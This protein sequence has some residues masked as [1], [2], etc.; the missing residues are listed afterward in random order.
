MMK[1]YDET[2][3][4]WLQLTEQKSG[5]QRKEYGYCPFSSLWPDSG[6]HNMVLRSEMAYELGG[7]ALPALGGTAVTE[8]AELV[9]ADMIELIGPDLQEIRSDTPYARLALIRVKADT[10]GEGEN[11]YQAIRKMEYV[12]YHMNPEGFMIR[13][14]ALH[15]QECVRVSKKALQ[16]GLTFEKTG[17]LFLEAW[18]RIPN[19]AAVRLIFITDPQFPYSELK[20]SVHR[21]D[22][23]TDGIDHIMKNLVMD[24]S[25]CRQKPLCD[26]VEGMRELHFA[27]AAR[28]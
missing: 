13:I 3:R 14:S 22:L 19:T 5:N 24:C 18:H 7:G 15:E 9:P 10:L 11:T 20:A 23:I 8:N 28:F 26:E 4:E 6:D 2:I 21:A 17:N 1:L 27:E 12:R 25:V 16:K